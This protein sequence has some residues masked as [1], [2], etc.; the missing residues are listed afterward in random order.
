[1]AF[2]DMVWAVGAVLGSEGTLRDTGATYNDPY[3]FEGGGRKNLAPTA[4]RIRGSYDPVGRQLTGVA[5][6]APISL[7]PARIAAR[8]P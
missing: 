7:A 5:F 3:Q 8:S 4:A 6:L 1:M 2:S